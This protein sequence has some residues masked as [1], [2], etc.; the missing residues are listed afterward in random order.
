MLFCHSSVL[1]WEVIALEAEI[2][3]PVFGSVINQAKIKR[4]IKTFLFDFYHH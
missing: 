3:C 1:G 4:M 2:T